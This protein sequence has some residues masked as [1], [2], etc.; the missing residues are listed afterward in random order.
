MRQIMKRIIFTIAI[1]GIAVQAMADNCNKAAALDVRSM[2]REFGQ[3]RIEGDHLVVHWTYKIEKQPEAERL[4][5][6]AAYA[7]MDACPAGGAREI[8]F[9]RA[10]KI[11]GIASPTSGIK[12]IE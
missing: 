4:R 12:L 7:N 1:A 10:G 2:I 3:Q 9:Y 8:H 5:M 11:M 6:V